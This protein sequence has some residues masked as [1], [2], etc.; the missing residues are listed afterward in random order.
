MATYSITLIN[1]SIC[2]CFCKWN[3]CEDEKGDMYWLWYSII[4]CDKG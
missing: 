4:A 2:L 3:G 1:E